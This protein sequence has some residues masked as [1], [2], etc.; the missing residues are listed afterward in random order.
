MYSAASNT[1]NT[2]WRNIY[3]QGKYADLWY[4]WDEKPLLLAPLDAATEEQKNFFT[5]RYAWFASHQGAGIPSDES[6][7]FGDGQDRWTWADYYPQ[8]AGWHTAGV[9]EQCSI[10]PATHVHTNRGRSFDV[11]TTTQPSNVTAET[12]GLGI[13]F[14]KQMER[15]LEIDPQFVLVSNWNEWV[16]QAQVG[17]ESIANAYKRAGD[18]QWVFFVDCMNM[19]FSRDIEPMR[20]GFGD[21]Y[22]YQLVDF[23]RKYKGVNKPVS[24]TGQH[25]ISID[26]LFNDWNDVQAVYG[27]YIND[28]SARVSTLWGRLGIAADN[29]GRNDFVT[30][31]VAS[32]DS[33][34]YFFA[35]CA[36]DITEAE[37]ANW[38]TLYL[39]TGTSESDW[40][41][42]DFVVNRT[43]GKIE[44]SVGGWNWEEV[45]NVSYHIEGNKLEL[46]LPLSS[47][48]I[49]TGSNFT[50]DFKWM[51]NTCT[52]GDIQDCMD[53]GDSAPDA[54]FKY[55]YKRQN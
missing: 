3:Q 41:G 2:L 32:D 50:L 13:H 5:I 11:E 33:R 34:V 6:A 20:G 42:F 17:N 36:E 35:E 26:G 39:S 29:T 45:G 27:D 8:E 10:A 22:Y 38:M 52:D 12:S 43:L 19:E 25:N 14:A 46:S 48:G 53:K 23:I 28:A 21:N 4:Y 7:W 55:R 37:A 18:N 24:Y 51:D 44:R 47:L 9:P 1:I 31:K 49:T 16:A 54:R 40:E 30:L 15:A